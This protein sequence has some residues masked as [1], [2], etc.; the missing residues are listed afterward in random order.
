[1]KRQIP[2]AWLQLIRQKGRFFVA[3]A[4]IGFADILMLMQLGFQNALLDSNTRPHQLLQADLVLI[5][6]EAQNLGSLD[7]F[8]R[9]RLFQ[10]RNLPEVKT[11]DPLYVR[12]G[13]WRNPQT[14]VESSILVLG[15]N[16]TKPAFNLPEINQTLNLIQ[17][18]D[19]LLFDRGSKGEYEDM[20]AQIAQ[21]NSVS[22]ELQGRK[23][24]LQGLYQ[25]GSSFVAD[26]SVITSDQNFL[27]IFAEQQASEVNV[28]LIT[29][30]LESDLN[31]VAAKLRTQ[32]PND[33]EVLTRQEFIE[34]ERNYWQRNTTI[35][36]VFSFGVVMG[37]VVGVIIVYQ[38]LYSDVTDHLAEYAT[39]KAMGYHNLYLLG[40]VFQEAM[41]LAVL[42]YLPGCLASV[43]LY[44][45]TRNAT[46]LPLF[47]T[48]ERVLQVLGVTLVM[49]MVSGAVAI[50]KLRSA[51]PADIF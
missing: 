24:T 16:P 30:K 13:V 10:A 38:I 50:R 28:G 35:G 18:P 23:V 32:L 44:Q 12:L 48:L 1:M 14:K 7:A 31:A 3:L 47:M 15:F 21:G 5:S 19:T 51:D 36:F 43:G 41:I 22:T 45:L 33:V 9:R 39:L 17:Y 20:I 8:P 29:L 40:V 42:G 4:G 34:F 26:G 2:L 27:R 37:F 25:I 6:L 46:S 11:A 49:C